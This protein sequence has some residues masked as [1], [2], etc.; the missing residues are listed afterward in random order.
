MP[1]SDFRVLAALGK[2]SY[3]SVMKVE[4][5]ADGNCYAMKEINIK[6]LSPRERCVLAQRQGGAGRRFAVRERSHMPQTNATQSDWWQLPHF[7]ASTVPADDCALSARVLIASPFTSRCPSRANPSPSTAAHQPAVRMRSTRSASWPASRA[8]TSS[9][10]LCCN[11]Q[12]PKNPAFA[13]GLQ[14]TATGGAQPSAH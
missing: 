2:G 6:R 9:G 5:L 4:R 8:G 7:H 10:E 3:G 12:T 14:R 1:L 13:Q 11:L